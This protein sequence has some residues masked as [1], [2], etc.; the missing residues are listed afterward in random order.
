MLA[1]APTDQLARNLLLNFTTEN[2]NT[3]YPLI[4]K[5]F[6]IIIIDSYMY[7]II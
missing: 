2:N 4:F 7:I 5:D 3:E 6:N 1:L